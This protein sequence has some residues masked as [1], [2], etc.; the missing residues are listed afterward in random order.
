[1]EISRLEKD[2]EV[3]RPVDL[4]EVTKTVA[5]I[6]EDVRK[7]GDTA[8]LEYSKR[9]DDY[10][11]KIQIQPG[12]I[13]KAYTQVDEDTLNAI[14]KA[15]ENIKAFHKA[16]I[17]K[18]IN[19]LLNGV[20][21]GQTARA[22]ESIG[23]YVPGG[24]AAYVSTVL[25]CAA[26]ARVAGVNQIVICTPPPVSPLVLLAADI[27]GVSTVYAVGGAQAIAAMAY[28]TETIPK[29]DKIVGPGNAYVAA[30]KKLV[31][32]DVGIDSIAGP[33][34]VL[35]IAD[36]QAEPK[37]IALE[38]LAQAEHDENALS[39]LVTTS[40]KVAK[41]T[42][43]E[44]KKRT[45]EC[46]RKE[47]L[48]K[49]LANSRILI[50]SSIDDAIGFSNRF[51]PEHLVILTKQDI[52]DRIKSAGSVF[53][54]NYASV[55]FGD[56]CSGTNHVLPTS[57]SARFQSGLNL[58]QFMKKLTWQRIGEGGYRQ[59]SDIAVKLAKSE[60]LYMH[61]KAVEER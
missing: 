46:D 6:V 19:M 7:N 52:L 43:E 9:F 10:K 57:G 25:M 20:E 11:G 2:E 27:C 21:L 22:I 29:V 59:L 30:A 31:F 23:I 14:R 8:V 35:I 56:Y 36:E 50:A 28:G 12:D 38:M 61:A 17:P 13:R 24:K 40:E 3:E 48:E 55:A 53:I 60:G 51:A 54:G 41:Q 18:D 5:P 49:S 16:Q 37:T 45:A 58:D 33:S 32:G 47:I 34:E 26:P 44:V 15:Y 1:M 4:G 39:V 42:V